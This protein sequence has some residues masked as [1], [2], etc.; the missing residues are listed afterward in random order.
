MRIHRRDPSKSNQ[1][2]YLV[3]DFRGQPIAK[4]HTYAGAEETA[5]NYTN[6]QH[7]TTKVYGPAGDLRWT[8][9]PKIET[10]H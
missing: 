5:I 4:R 1:P 6:V 7:C 8:C 2:Q 9:H 10:V 3:V